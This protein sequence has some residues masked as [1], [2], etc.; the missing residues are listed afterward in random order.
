MPLITNDLTDS[1]TLAYLNQAVD[2]AKTC[3]D[4]MRQGNYPTA[5]HKASKA[6]KRI[7]DLI[8]L[9]K[10]TAPEIG[11][12]AAPFYYLQANSLITYVE[13]TIDVFG[14]VP[15]LP[16]PEDSEEESGDEEGEEGEEGSHHVQ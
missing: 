3:K 11:V 1:D 13:N 8:E 15:Q 4:L 16:E 10:D 2:Y 6:V 5:I 14:N 12:S 7:E 9:K